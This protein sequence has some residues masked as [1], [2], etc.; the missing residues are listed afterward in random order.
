MRAQW[1]GVTALLVVFSSALSVPGL[2]GLSGAA[3]PLVM[4]TLLL[5][6]LALVIAAPRQGRPLV[7]PGVTCQRAGFQTRSPAREC[8]PDAAGHV[9]P[10]A[11]GVAAVL[12]AG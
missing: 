12:L 2:S 11:P 8:D 6:V 9:R 4:T 10:R 1:A 3:V 7:R 5:A